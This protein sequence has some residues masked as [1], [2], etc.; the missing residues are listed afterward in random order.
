MQMMKPILGTMAAAVVGIIAL[1][2]AGTAVAAKAKGHQHTQERS[3]EIQRNPDEAPRP[4]DLGGSDFQ[5]QGRF[6]HS[7][8]VHRS[9]ARS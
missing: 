7:R 4:S 8:R 5:L 2:A 1:S 6:Y 3:I 9:Q